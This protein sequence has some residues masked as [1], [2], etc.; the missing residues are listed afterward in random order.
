MVPQA[1]GPVRPE[2]ALLARFAAV[3]FLM[4][5]SLWMWPYSDNRGYY[6]SSR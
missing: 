4:K 3:L 5:L 6:G 1:T 2:R